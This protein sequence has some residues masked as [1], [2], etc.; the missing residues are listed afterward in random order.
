MIHSA[1]SKLKACAGDEIDRE[2]PED[3]GLVSRRGVKDM[4][5]NLNG[6]PC[7]TTSSNRPR[8]YRHEKVPAGE[9][10]AQA[11]SRSTDACR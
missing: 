1:R 7:A 8:R 10:T 4:T 6:V 2:I 9:E 5:E 11:S 3:H